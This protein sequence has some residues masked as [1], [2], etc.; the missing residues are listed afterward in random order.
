MTDFERNTKICPTVAGNNFQ[1]LCEANT[2]KTKVKMKEI[3]ERVL[4]IWG[5]KTYTVVNQF[6]TEEDNNF[7]TVLSLGFNTFI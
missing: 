5:F 7:D 2:L 4:Q 3:L 6:R 1:V